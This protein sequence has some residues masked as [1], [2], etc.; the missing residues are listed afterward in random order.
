MS[1]LDVVTA[2]VLLILPV[3]GTVFGFIVVPLA[4]VVF[5]MVIFSI[6]DKGE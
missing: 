1:A 6:T 3:V 4:T 2:I 5:L